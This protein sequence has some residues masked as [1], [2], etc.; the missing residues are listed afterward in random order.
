MK[1]LLTWVLC[2]VL[3]LGAAGCTRQGQGAFP[4]KEEPTR[5][6][7]QAMEA[8]AARTAG[9]VITPEREENLCYSP[10]SLYVAEG[11]AAWGLEGEARQAVLA[12]LYGR[13]DPEQM[14][15][16]MNSLLNWLNSGGEEQLIVANSLWIDEGNADALPADFEDQARA[17]YDAPVTTGD[18]GGEKMARQMSRWVAENTHDKLKPAIEAGQ[19]KS[20]ALNALYFKGQWEKPFDKKDTREQAFYGPGGPVQSDFMHRSFGGHAFVQAA[21]YTGT[22]LEM[23]NGATMEF[24]LPREGLTPADLLADEGQAAQILTWDKAQWERGRVR[25]ALPKF[26]YGGAMDLTG[27]MPPGAELRV[28]QGTY[29]KVDEQGAEAAAYTAAAGGA[30]PEPPKELDLVLDRPFLYTLHAPDGTLLFVGAVQDP[31]A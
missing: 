18:L 30:A 11:L 24:I 5:Q 10:L 17:V 31:T 27:L 9:Q 25:L 8:F 15:K 16:Q 3:A 23:S 14:G 7:D 2:T 4:P 20:V 29:I 22:V 26:E 13:E 12:Q 6:L 28:E 1:R 19:A 21:D